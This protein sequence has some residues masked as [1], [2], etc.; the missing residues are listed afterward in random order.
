MESIYITI[1]FVFFIGCVCGALIAWALITTMDK[2]K[3][4]KIPKPTKWMDMR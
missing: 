1:F 4:F 2:D 3:Q